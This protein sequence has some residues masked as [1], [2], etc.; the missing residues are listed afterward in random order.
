MAP[1]RREFEITE[2][3][4]P[5]QQGAPSGPAAGGDADAAKVAK[6]FKKKVKAGAKKPSRGTRL[7]I[8]LN[9]RDFKLFQALVAPQEPLASRHVGVSTPFLGLFPPVSLSL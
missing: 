4:A 8:K 6:P 9:E 1:S 2:P 7:P 5:T 3:P